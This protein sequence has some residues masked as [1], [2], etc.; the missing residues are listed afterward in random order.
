MA[1]GWAFRGG[2]S[3]D[4]CCL[5]HL[6][7]EI[8]TDYLIQSTHLVMGLLAVI[9]AVGRWLELRLA[10]VQRNAAA[11]A[12]VLHRAELTRIKMRL[13]AQ[14]KAI[15]AANT[16]MGTAAEFGKTIIDAAIRD[17][18]KR[19]RAQLRMAGVMAIARAAV[20]TVEAA[21]AFARYD[22]IGGALHTAAAALGYVQGG[23]MLAGR[24]P[25]Q[26]GGSSSVG[27][28]GSGSDTSSS[29]KN[30]SGLK[31]KSPATTLLGNVEQSV[32]SS[33]TFAL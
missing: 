29:S 14:R 12:E 33:R 3:N 22:F 31:P 26:G 25:S 8:K 11:R 7:F 10:D 9:M 15:Q 32:F 16:A 20:E 17:D 19:E 24:L 2:R 6:P 5:A 13:D 1:R 23:I 28:G 21:A 27:G 30:D 4:R 18:A